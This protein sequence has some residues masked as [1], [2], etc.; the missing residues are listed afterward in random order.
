MVPPIHCILVE[1]LLD[2]LSIQNGLS[3]LDSCTKLILHTKQLVRVCDLRSTSLTDAFDLS[4][5][6]ADVGFILDVRLVELDVC[7]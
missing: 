6:E 2:E 5:S 4:A 7:V 3:E 1:L